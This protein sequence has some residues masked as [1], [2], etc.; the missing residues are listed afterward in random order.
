MLQPVQRTIASKCRTRQEFL[1]E[2]GN[3]CPAAPS[4]QSRNTEELS[5]GLRPMMLCWKPGMLSPFISY[6]RKTEACHVINCHNCE[7]QSKKMRYLKWHMI[8]R[9]T[10]WLRP[11]KDIFLKP[12]QK[13]S[14]RWYFGEKFTSSFRD[15]CTAQWDS[16]S[17]YLRRGKVIG[18]NMAH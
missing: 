2:H 13:N 1:T 17:R 3:H 16:T 12:M 10:V 14:K 5:K 4:G 6:L 9:D 18:E 11:T 7:N 8:K 15:K